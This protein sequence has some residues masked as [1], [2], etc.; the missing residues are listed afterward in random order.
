MSDQANLG[1]Y[2]ESNLAHPS[3]S[4]SDAKEFQSEPDYDKYAAMMELWSKIHPKAHLSW[5]EGLE[6]ARRLQ[7]GERSVSVLRKLV[8]K[9][10]REEVTDVEFVR[11]KFRTASD[12]YPIMQDDVS[13]AIPLALGRLMGMGSPDGEDEQAQRWP[14]LWDGHF[15]PRTIFRPD[16]RLA[17]QYADE[18][19][20]I[21]KT[22]RMGDAFELETMDQNATKWLAK[23]ADCLR[24]ATHVEWLRN[25][26]IR[27]PEVS[28]HGY[29][30]N[31][32]FPQLTPGA[33]L[34]TRISHEQSLST[35]DDGG[36]REQRQHPQDHPN[37]NDQ[38]E[39]SEGQTP[40][41]GGEDKGRYGGNWDMKIKMHSAPDAGGPPAGEHDNNQL[42][43]VMEPSN[44]QSAALNNH[45]QDVEMQ[46]PELIGQPPGSNRQ[47]SPT[48][49]EAE[50]ATGPMLKRPRCRPPAREDDHTTGNAWS[51]AR[52]ISLT[53][54]LSM[55]AVQS[56]ETYSRFLEVEDNWIPYRAWSSARRRQSW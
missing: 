4:H 31:G 56:Y 17:V 50:M 3:A 6:T 26:T 27:F 25:W 33:Q 22:A 20:Q 1:L 48:A 40:A 49:S 38:M 23:L 11:Y 29:G 54:D 24:D 55:D 52:I 18:I 19:M 37:S 15:V 44:G 43:N 5:R 16:L 34:S 46:A 13:R 53:N 47:P 12:R 39:I 42:H 35:G 8:T 28:A 7:A 2:Q 32:Q 14:G 30:P 9:A 45:I 10:M 21:L 51:S 41:L 36:P